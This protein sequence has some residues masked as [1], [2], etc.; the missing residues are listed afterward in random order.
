MTNMKI[1]LNDIH[2]SLKQSIRTNISDREKDKVPDE[3]K[4]NWILK[5]N[6][7]SELKQEIITNN[8]ILKEYEKWTYLLLSII[9]NTKICEGKHHNYDFNSNEVHYDF[10]SKVQN[11][12]LKI[13][14][15]EEENFNLKRKLIE[16]S[17]I[18]K[19]Y[20]KLISQINSEI[21]IIK[22]DQNKQQ[23]TVEK[24]VESLTN[25]INNII[26]ELDSL[27]ASNAQ[28]EANIDN[29]TR[30]ILKLKKEMAELL[31]EKN[32]L[33]CI[34]KSK[35]P[36]PLESDQ[37]KLIERSKLMKKKKVKSLFNLD[38]MNMLSCFGDNNISSEK[39]YTISSYVYK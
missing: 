10:G 26:E 22:E 35:S 12:L 5:D 37:I 31:N 7:V 6:K 1:D 23:E 39:R 17:A 33:Q 27:Y 30:L 13:S 8:N 28:Y 4:L 9:N 29:D 18:S 24:E 34:R 36:I 3:D 21:K 2:K 11:E 20:T 14:D 25:N 32:D 38:K 15:I 16:K 19:E